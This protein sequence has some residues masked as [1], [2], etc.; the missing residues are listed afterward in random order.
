MKKTMLC[1]S[2]IVMLLPLTVWG[3]QADDLYRQYQSAKQKGQYDV[4]A[5]YLCDAA[6]IDQKYGKECDSVSTY[7]N[8]RLTQFQ[9]SFDVGKAEFDSN[10]NVK[11]IQ[12]LSKITFGP[13]RD[14][15]QSLI[16]Q[17]QARLT[18]PATDPNADALKAAQLAYANNDFPT[19]EANAQQ[20]KSA[21]LQPQA[22]TILS[23]IRNYNDDMQQAQAFQASKN[24]QAAQQKY[25]AAVSIK[26]NGP[27]NPAGKLQEVAALISAKPTLANSNKSAPLDNSAKIKAYL[28]DASRHAAQNDWQA[29]ITAYNQALVLD[30]KQPEALAGKTQAQ[31]QMKAAL[32]K[33]PKAL[34]KTLV[35]GIQN[36]YA[37]QF[38]EAE[39]AISIYLG[40]GTQ[41]LGAAHFYLGAALL[42][43][44]IVSDPKNKDDQ[45]HLQQTAMQQ[46]QEAKQ[47]NFKP[48]QKYVSPKILAVW[49]QPGM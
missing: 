16:A 21:E 15:A 4:A 42:S 33:D 45:N 43:Q 37:G 29:A 31:E 6:K 22:Q 17:A 7:V 40:I 12:D 48:A 20:V 34:E 13:K 44:A 18:R 46:F 30:P 38:S 23:N 1:L 5:K 35:N 8:Q 9:S 3:Q 10:E 36:Y 32:A 47:A 26:P 11:A 25:Q 39:Q 2:T 14:E 19:A 41:N 24:Y 49:N 27:G 28:A